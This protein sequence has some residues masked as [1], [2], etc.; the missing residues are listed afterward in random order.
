MDLYG[1]LAIFFAFFGLTCVGCAFVFVTRMERRQSAAL[2]ERVGAHKSV[3]GKLAKR[4]PLSDDEIAY[5][6]EMVADCRSP[7]A[8]AI[9]GFLLS[10]ACFYVFGCL[11]QLHGGHPTI[12]TFIGGLPVLG[13]TNLTVRMRLVA[14]LEKPLKQAAQNR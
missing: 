1:L 4:Q 6:R 5:A 3:L 10:M 7:L 9:P 14:R 2:G 11:H 12:R 13:A 8:Y